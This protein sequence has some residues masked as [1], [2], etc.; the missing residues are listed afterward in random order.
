MRKAET[1]AIVTKHYTFGTF[2]TPACTKIFS[3]S[4]NGICSGRMTV[5]LVIGFVMCAVPR[6]I[7]LL[8]TELPGL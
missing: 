8:P 1:V 6:S 5:Y 7:V 3:S 4:F 2:L